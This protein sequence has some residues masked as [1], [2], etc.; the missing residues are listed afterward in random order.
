MRNRNMKILLIGIG[1]VCVMIA[2]IAVEV[3]ATPHDPS[4][5]QQNSMLHR[6]DEAQRDARANTSLLEHVPFSY[7]PYMN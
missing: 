1:I 3:I 6:N 4:E 2:V 5:E 7:E